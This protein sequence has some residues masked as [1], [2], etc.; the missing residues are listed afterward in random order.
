MSSSRCVFLCFFV[1]F[2]AA[3]SYSVENAASIAPNSD[4][5]Y[6][7]LRNVT[8]SGEAVTVSNV[9][10]RRDAATFLLRSG[11]VCFV[12]PVQGKVTGAVFA[13][14]GNLTLNPPI[15]VERASL[16]LLTKENEFSETSA[17]WYCASLMPP[18]TT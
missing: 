12:A 8:L 2:I 1:C 18:T 10:L 15:M 17:R 14:D 7:Q 16:K 9:A 3:S 4:P 5:S 6:Q 11:T 13:G